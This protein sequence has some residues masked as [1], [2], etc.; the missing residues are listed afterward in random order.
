M[1]TICYIHIPV[2][3]YVEN[4]NAANIMRGTRRMV[5]DQIRPRKS[6]IEALNCWLQSVSERR[7]ISKMENVGEH[8]VSND[9]PMHSPIAI[10]ARHRRVPFDLAELKI[11]IT[12]KW[13]KCEYPQCFCGGVK[14]ERLRGA[15]WKCMINMKF[16]FSF[17]WNIINNYCTLS[18]LR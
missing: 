15:S 2:F 9:S 18:I 11:V 8:G 4:K 12:N 16:K 5:A 13:E 3:F 1:I 14:H 10:I 7:H 17:N 6:L